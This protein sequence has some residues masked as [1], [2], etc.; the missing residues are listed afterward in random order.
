MPP[1]AAK[2]PAMKGRVLVAQPG[3]PS[4]AINA[5]LRGV[6]EACRD[7]P[8]RTTIDDNIPKD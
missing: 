6:L 3:G 4:P 7:Y 1:H 5:S 2:E 8:E